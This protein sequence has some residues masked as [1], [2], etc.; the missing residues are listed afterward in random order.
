MTDTSNDVPPADGDYNETV[1]FSPGQDGTEIGLDDT[2]QTVLFGS[3][4]GDA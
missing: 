3:S 2:G 1:Y 4:E